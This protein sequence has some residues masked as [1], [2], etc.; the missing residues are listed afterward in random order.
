VRAELGFTTIEEVAASGYPLRLETHA[1]DTIAAV[2]PMEVLTHYHLTPDEIEAKGGNTRVIGRGDYRAG[3]ADFIIGNLYLGRTAVTQSWFTATEHQNM[4]FLE[5]GD[6]I[7]AQ[8]TANG[9]GKPGEIPFHFLR[10]VD[11]P[12]KAL[13]QAIDLLIYCPADADEDFVHTLTKLYDSN[14][15]I[16]FN[17][18]FHMAW[19]PAQA[20][21][22]GPLEL[23]P[24]AERYYREA[25]LL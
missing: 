16:F 8:L 24:G 2:L 22:T 10:G 5:L 23:H 21:R 12:I 17:Q 1:L 25:G 9:H 6:D 11:R 13:Q 7:L 20:V 19:D 18:S 3:D 15:G 4:R 14:R